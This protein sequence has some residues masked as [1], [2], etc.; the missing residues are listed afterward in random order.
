MKAAM[1]SRVLVRVRAGEAQKRLVGLREAFTPQDGL[2]GLGHHGPVVF[3]VRPDR[4]LV[5][6]QLAEPFQKG[7]QGN[8]RVG[9]RDTDVADD[10]G[11]GQVQLQPAVA[12]LAAR[13]SS[14]ALATPRFPSEFSKSMGLTLWGMADEPTS[15]A[16]IFC[17]K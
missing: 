10:R 17:L 6:D 3:E 8:Q 1:V 9:Q 4:L 7:L 5:Q 15:P 12:E 2:N 16:L 14:R 13:C 11:V